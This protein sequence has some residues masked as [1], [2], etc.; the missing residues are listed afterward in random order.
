M[1]KKVVIFYSLFTLVMIGG[2][3]LLSLWFFPKFGGPYLVRGIWAKAGMIE[4][5]MG[6][7][8]TDFRSWKIWLFLIA[9]MAASVSVMMF[10]GKRLEKRDQLKKPT[11]VQG[12]IFKITRLTDKSAHDV[13]CKAAEDWPVSREQIEQDFEKF[14][15]DDSVPYYVNDFIRKNKKNIDGLS[16]SIFQFPGVGSDQ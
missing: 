11:S 6:Y 16:V 13:F 7:T 1:N 2:S 14:L 3:L 10:V 9:H 15:I 5:E 8:M 4:P 12:Y